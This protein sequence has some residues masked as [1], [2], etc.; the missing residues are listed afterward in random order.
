MKKLL[1]FIGLTA[2]VGGTIYLTTFFNEEGDELIVSVK[3]PTV[4]SKF[5]ERITA[6][7]DLKWSNDSIESLKLRI[8]ISSSSG[9]I[10]SATKSML[11]NTLENTESLCLQ[12]SFDYWVAND[13]D[14]ALDS[15]IYGRIKT[16]VQKRSFDSKL[17]KIKKALI[18]YDKQS[19]LRQEVQRSLMGFFD[20][21]KQNSLEQKINLHLNNPLIRNCAVI[22][23]T[24]LDLIDELDLFEAFNGEYCFEFSLGDWNDFEYW[25]DENPNFFQK[26]P[27][28]EADF[29][30]V[31]ND[32]FISF[33]EHPC[34]N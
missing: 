33:I 15:E 5:N 34:N 16:L 1:V 22:Q 27:K 14:N 25:H 11:L 26:Y 4:E 23:N 19:T 13:S 10:A 30:R 12:N 32:G 6:L 2:L 17:K 20:A 3:P 8:E 21:T 31:K 28:Y 7:E 29:K 18:S 24:R 9:K